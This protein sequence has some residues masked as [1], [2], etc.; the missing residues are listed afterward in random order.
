M[1][2]ALRRRQPRTVCATKQRQTMTER[3]PNWRMPAWAREEFPAAENRAAL[4][5]RHDVHG[6]DEALRRADEAEWERLGPLQR[7]A[8]VV[9]EVRRRHAPYAQRL[10]ALDELV[11]GL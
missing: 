10:K 5:D 7:A 9:A 1:G 2:P 8:A 3:H 6:A 11:E 4:L